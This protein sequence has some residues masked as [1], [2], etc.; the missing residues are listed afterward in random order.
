MAVYELNLDEVAYGYEPKNL[1]VL[2]KLNLR[3]KPSLDA[4][5]IR[6]MPVGEKVEVL[7]DDGEWAT[8]REGFCMIK[9]LG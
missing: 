5:V 4:K 9:F 2:K 8:L 6:I 3:E 7:F 1:K